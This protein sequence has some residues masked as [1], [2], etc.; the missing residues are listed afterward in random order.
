MTLPINNEKWEFTPSAAGIAQLNTAQRYLDR[1]IIVDIPEG[2]LS[3]TG[4]DVTGINVT[5]SDDAYTG[6]SVIGSGKGSVTE[7]GWIDAGEA[8][9]SSSIEK[10]IIGI[11]VPSFGAF[12][13]VTLKPGSPT[14][15]TIAHLK[16]D[17]YTKF[18][19]ENASTTNPSMAQ[20]EIN[21]LLYKLD[22]GNTAATNIATAS[23]GSSAQFSS[24][25]NIFTVGSTSSTSRTTAAKIMT[26]TL[27]GY[28]PTYSDSITTLNVGTDQTYN[29]AGIGTINNYG[30]IN[31]IK[32]YGTAKVVAGGSTTDPA[33]TLNVN[34]YDAASPAALTGYKTIVTNGRWNVDALKD[35]VGTVEYNPAT[36]I[37][38][39]S[40]Y[41]E[42]VTTAGY[43]E[44]NRIQG[45]TLT[46]NQ[47]FDITVPNGTS[48]NITFHFHVDASGNVTVD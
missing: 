40:S 26:L 5:L 39:D 42:L 14:N 44:T 11:T 19:I 36:T 31:V 13:G 46:N 27:R 30:T 10:S 15:S 2:T 21:T 37:A 18:Y 16:I 33:G 38:T 20:G 4:A 8:T 1:D 7:S 47:N 12:N 41:P 6:I 35:V 43:A 34:A 25:I 48:G 22:I 24:M 29:N 9:E 45:V 3:S 23:L 32:N 17:S 28:G